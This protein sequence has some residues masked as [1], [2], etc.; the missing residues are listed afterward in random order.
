[1]NL[2]GIDI[3]IDS[4]GV[5]ILKNDEI[6]LFNFSTK[7]KDY[8]W[9]KKT[10]NYINYDFISYNYKNIDTYSEKEL[11]K[12]REFDN[13]ST[14][15]VNKIIENIDTD[16]KTIIAIEGYNFGFNQQSN[17]II[18][19]VTL[20][21]LIRK[22]L[23]VIHNLENIIIWSPKNIKS[24]LCK[25]VYGETIIEK[26]NKKGVKKITKTINQSIDNVSGGNFDKFDVMK[27]I[28]NLN[29]DTKLTPFLMEN[30]DILLKMK[31]LPKPFDDV[32]DSLSILMLLKN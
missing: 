12:L 21:T 32:L 19:I 17:S 30:K 14:L 20:S 18:D 23:L 24:M 22:K 31:E 3:S 2:I 11:M 4:T 10:L 27:A 6:K 28:I 13:V 5:S 9:I 26:V 29:I 16:Q 8:I 15:I 25:L 1:M 7:K